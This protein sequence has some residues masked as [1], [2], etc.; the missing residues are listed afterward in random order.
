M[1]KPDEIPNE[2]DLDKVTDSEKER[3]GLIKHVTTLALIAS[4]GVYVIIGII[5]TIIKDKVMSVADKSVADKSVADM[6][7]ADKPVA[8]MPMDANFDLSVL[9]ENIAKALSSDSRTFFLFFAVAVFH[10]AVI[11]GM[12]LIL[13]FINKY[14]SDTRQRLMACFMVICVIMGSMLVLLYIMTISWA[15]VTFVLSTIVI[16]VCDYALKLSPVRSCAITFGSIIILAFI[17]S[18]LEFFN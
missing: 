6:P 3:I 10:M 4:A 16:F 2:K 5:V 14:T 12:M 8:D 7:V 15:I 1:N 9:T 13:F 11:A 18:I 17:I